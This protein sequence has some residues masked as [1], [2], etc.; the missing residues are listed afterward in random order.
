MSG[1]ERRAE[2]SET[3]V[4]PYRTFRNEVIQASD[5]EGPGRRPGNGSSE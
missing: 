1:L 5:A 4:E 2:V 3:A